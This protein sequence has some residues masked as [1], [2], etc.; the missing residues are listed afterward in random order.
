MKLF[1]SLLLSITL[2]GGLNAD[3]KFNKA[4]KKNLDKI[5][6]L[7]TAAEFIDVA[8]NFERIALAE[9]SEWLP[10]YYASYLYVIASYME[11]NPDSK[12]MYLDKADG[13]ISIADSIKPDNSEIFTVKGMANQARLQIDPMNRWM[14]YG[15]LS[16]TYL[17]KAI[18]LDSLN[19]R[20]EYLIGMSVYYMPEQFGGGEKAAQPY[21][22]NALR[23]F[24]EFVPESELHPS[25]GKTMFQGFLN[26][27]KKQ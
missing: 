4:M 22:D 21:F 15:Q 3:D 12:D 1:L 5:E 19:P 6:T 24:E 10:Y 26:S 8:N 9:K 11:Q 18:E 2:I 23:K 20:P 14:K 27:I 16:D 13:F 17:K 7:K 25:W